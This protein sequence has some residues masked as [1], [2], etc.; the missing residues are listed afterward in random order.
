MGAV[1]ALSVS[2]ARACANA[3]VVRPAPGGVG[4]T[5]GRRAQGA[6]C[7]RCLRAHFRPHLFPFGFPP[8][9]RRLIAASACGRAPRRC[10]GL[11]GF[12]TARL[13]APPRTLVPAASPLLGA[14]LALDAAFGLTTARCE[15]QHATGAGRTCDGPSGIWHQRCQ[16]PNPGASMSSMSRPSPSHVRARPGP[17][18]PRH[19]SQR[20][21]LRLC[22][23]CR[24]TTAWRDSSF[25]ASHS[26]S[27][28]WMLAPGPRA[29]TP[30]PYGRLTKSGGRT[31]PARARTAGSPPR[32]RQA[33]CQGSTR[34][35][36]FYRICQT[37][38]QGVTA[39]GTRPGAAGRSRRGPP[40]SPSPVT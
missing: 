7:G 1:G 34:S 24:N 4:S 2:C 20:V 40:S 3:R 14:G 6:G 16:R 33:V 8:G 22:P 29:P 37:R 11:L 12:P 10:H 23:L 15:R 38:G 25:R 13:A 26:L 35:A 5:A 31:T 36:A 21:K 27:G 30:E 9:R 32:P 39:P 28:S 17:A 18:G 19:A